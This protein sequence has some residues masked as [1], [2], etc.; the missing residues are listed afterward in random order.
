M[1]YTFV[2]SWLVEF[3]KLFASLFSFLDHSERWQPFRSSNKH[4][5]GTQKRS[6]QFQ[7]SCCQSLQPA[8]NTSKNKNVKAS[9]NTERIC[10][11]LKVKLDLLLF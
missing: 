7:L 4:L 1:D 10:L 8:D 6:L 9:H 3:V 2:A 5:C 11:F